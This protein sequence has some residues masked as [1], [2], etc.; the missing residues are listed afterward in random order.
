MFYKW[1][2]SGSHSVH[3]GRLKY[4]LNTDLPV[5][6]KISYCNPTPNMTTTGSL[7]T[8]QSIIQWNL[9]NYT[10]N[11]LHGPHL[12]LQGPHLTLHGLHWTLYRPL[13]HYRTTFNTTWAPLNNVQTTQ[14][15][16]RPP[17]TL[18]GPHFTLHGPPSTLY[19][20]LS[21]WHGCP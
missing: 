10:F 13:K 21:T 14:M 19:G 2:F 8:C 6:G 1:G 3:I 4:S 5:W 17:L 7:C 20:P 11:K 18:H 9:E 16:Q 12:T 15:L